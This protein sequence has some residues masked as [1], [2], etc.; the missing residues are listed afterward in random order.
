MAKPGQKRKA[1][2]EAMMK[3]SIFEATLNVLKKYGMEGLRMDRVARTA[4]VATGTV[5]NYFKDKEELV[6]YVIDNIFDPYLEILESTRNRE[7]TPTEKLKNFIRTALEGFYEHWD[8]I[9]VLINS[10]AVAFG[11]RGGQ[12]GTGEIRPK[13]ADLLTGIIEDGIRAGKF[14][15]CDAF[16]V[17][18]MIF[19]AIEGLLSLKISGSDEKETFNEEEVDECLAFLLPGLLKA[20]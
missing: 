8:V 13:I 6:L 4:E 5:Y 12:I 11:D 19:G 20:A 3:N 7:G 17:S 15:F 10:Q 14:R 18:Y 9:N 16:R 1:A 2:W